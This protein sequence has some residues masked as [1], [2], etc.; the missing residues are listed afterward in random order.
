MLQGQRNTKRGIPLLPDV[1]KMHP[2]HTMLYFA[3]AASGFL[4]LVL[5]G[6]YTAQRFR[7]SN[8]T[9]DL[10]LP[11]AFIFSTLVLLFCSFAFMKARQHFRK[12]ALKT[13]LRYLTAGLSL[14]MVFTALQIIGWIEFYS[15]GYGLPT[16]NVA[17]SYVFFI[18]GIHFMHML[19]ALGFG[20]AAWIKC[21]RKSRHVV[22]ELILL[23]N[24]FEKQK[25]DML[26]RFWHYVDF[27]W[28]CLFICFV[29]TF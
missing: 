27:L 20:L 3:M 15:F 19:I 6:L 11:K 24:P 9:L 21:F 29:L 10:E 14:G 8:M 7:P 23:T 4:F 26:A 22:D 17:S 12:D 16:S 1:R 5:M 28:V 18:T 25:M 2:Y 13:T